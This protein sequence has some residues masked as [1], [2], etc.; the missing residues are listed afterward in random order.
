MDFLRDSACAVITRNSECSPDFGEARGT[1][2]GASNDA[3]KGE[4]DHKQA[5][6]GRVSLKI[7]FIQS[8]SK[9]SNGLSHSSA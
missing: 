7:I 1:T 3:I 8:S 2:D 5:A 9:E 6:P 4:L